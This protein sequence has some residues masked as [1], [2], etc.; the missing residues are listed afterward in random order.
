MHMTFFS[1]LTKRSTLPIL[2]LTLAAAFPAACADAGT[3]AKHN[4]VDRQGE[5]VDFNSWQAVQDFST[6]MVEQHGFDRAD[7]EAVFKNARHID[8]A[9][10][11]VKP[12]PVGQPKNWQAYRARFI[13]PKRIAA[14]LAF[15]NEHAEALARAEKEYGVPAEIIVG[16][17]GIE[18]LYGQN[19]GSFRV[20]DVLATL[21]FDYPD[22]PNRTARMDYFRSELENALLFARESSIDPFSLKGSY[23]GAIGLPQFMPGSIRKFAVDYDGDGKIDLRN[24]PEDAIG[25]IAN[26]LTQHGWHRGEPT[27]FQASVTT[28]VEDGKNAWTSYIG[29][30]L[31]AKFSLA[32]LEA[33]GVRP[34]VEPPADILYGLVDLQNGTEPT[35]YWLG[36]PNFFAITQYNRSFF[37]AMSVIEL[38]REVRT[39][40]DA[41]KLYGTP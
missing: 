27:V 17:L 5:Y 28:P 40:R 24:S 39:L 12:A 7:L 33:A 25:S 16:I 34:V 14:G 37:Y 32:E 6:M 13:E 3:K 31:E 15:W 21:G 38:G 19:T 1:S 41:G 4:A 26:F 29:Q 36:A 20:V 30:G 10:Q 22:T 2:V 9:I 35:E 23:A 11:L 8:S 18:T